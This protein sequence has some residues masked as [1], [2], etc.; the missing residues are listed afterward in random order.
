MGRMSKLK[1]RSRWRSARRR[2][3]PAAQ[4]LEVQRLRVAPPGEPGLKATER[5]PR[6]ATAS[7]RVRVTA[8]RAVAVGVAVATEDV[9]VDV[10]GVWDRLHPP[11]RMLRVSYGGFE[12]SGWAGP[13]YRGEAVR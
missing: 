7:R 8:P 10:D 12:G 5:A 9:D 13:L 3:R 6:V 2:N 4:V 1:R 11:R